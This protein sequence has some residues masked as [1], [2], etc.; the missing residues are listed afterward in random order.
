MPHRVAL[1]LV[2]VLAPTTA[3]PI[4]PSP[5]PASIAG[6]I[7]NGRVLESEHPE[8]FTPMVFEALLETA[9]KVL[10][11]ST[12][13]LAVEHIAPG[14]N[15]FTA[16]LLFVVLAIS[17]GFLFN[18]EDVV[19]GA[20]VLATL[21]GSFVGF[22]ILFM[23]AFSSY[24]APMEGDDKCVTPFILTVLCSLAVTCIVAALIKQFVALS[25]FAIA[26]GAALLG[27]GLLRVKVLEGEPH[28]L[29][30][31]GWVIGYW[32][33]TVIA[34]IVAGFAA[35]VQRHEI[36]I[37]STVA[38]GSFGLAASIRGLV[39]VFHNPPMP[40][41]GFWLILIFSAVAG[42]LCQGSMLYQ[43]K[44]QKAA[45]RPSSTRTDSV[46]IGRVRIELGPRK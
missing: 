17:I 24:E 26:A 35:L 16:I 5:T 12:L 4:T 29:E 45:T 28:L 32:I 36:I 10:A 13:R 39:E 43:K 33:A 23:D 14:E 9:T 19:K 27:M 7:V 31:E 25:V 2:A 44:K 15:T 20:I 30:D 41:H 6:N 18:G 42:L 8:C 3:L 46:R 11:Y 40:D 22:L 1:F 21:A 38:I 34:G 37:V